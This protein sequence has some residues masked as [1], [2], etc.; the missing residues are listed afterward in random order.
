MKTISY[1]VSGAAVLALCFFALHTSAAVEYTITD[2]GTLVSSVCRESSAAS[3]SNTGYV[4][5]Q[6]LTRNGAHAFLWK[7]GQMSDLGNL[8]GDANPYGL[9]NAGQVVGGSYLSQLGSDYHAF[10]YADGRMNDLGTF[11]GR[12]AFGSGINDRGQ[13]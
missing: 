12:T 13:V 10:L 11:G 7:Y 8:G 4:T 1:R 6:S 9:N 2:M 5:G 3:I